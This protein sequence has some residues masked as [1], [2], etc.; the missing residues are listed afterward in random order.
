MQGAAAAAQEDCSTQLALST[1]QRRDSL[2]D[3]GWATACTRAAGSR[4]GTQP[5]A[6][7][8]SCFCFTATAV[9][10]PSP[11]GTRFR[12]CQASLVLLTALH[13]TQTGCFPSRNE[14][15]LNLQLG[16]SLCLLLSD[17]C[18]LLN[19][20]LRLVVAGNHRLKRVYLD[21]RVLSI[22]VV[23]NLQQPRLSCSASSAAQF[24]LDK[25][26]IVNWNNN[27][28]RSFDSNICHWGSLIHFCSSPSQT[29]KQAQTTEENW[30]WTKW[31]LP[32]LL[33]S[34]WTPQVWKESRGLCW[35]FWL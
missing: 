14:Q 21:C 31:A 26:Y 19:S 23:S 13:I 30:L 10:G 7:S 28:R 15:L 33:H 6:S 2:Q 4:D 11:S 25:D 22:A 9:R 1:G 3:K 5:L 27:S 35:A 24:C 20:N 16:P 29:I 18:I 34:A 17:I 12:S 32:E 8:S